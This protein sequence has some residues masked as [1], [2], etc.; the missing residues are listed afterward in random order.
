MFDLL[1]TY[2]GHHKADTER[3]PLSKVTLKGLH[4]LLVEDNEMN[5][6]IAVAILEQAGLQITT[7]V[8][9]QDAVNQFTASI[10]GTYDAI[11]MDIQMPVMDG[12]EATRAIRR[13]SH[14]EARTMPIIAV[15][16][17]VFSEDVAKALACG[18]NDYISKPI[19]YPK[20]IKALLK[21]TDP[22][23]RH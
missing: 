17:D 10:P 16:A 9:G 7:A 12:Y 14:P 21:F 22:A 5:R 4:I 15:T 23:K 8:N 19:D 13:S 20:L 1:M 2:F 6:E 18:M 11:F 3:P